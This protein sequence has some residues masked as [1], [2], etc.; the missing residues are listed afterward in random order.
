MP[1]QAVG[2][3]G[4]RRSGEQHH[5]AKSAGP[6]VHILAGGQEEQTTAGRR[7]RDADTLNTAES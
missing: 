1:S 6:V 2:D 4:Q 5:K 7:G 3:N